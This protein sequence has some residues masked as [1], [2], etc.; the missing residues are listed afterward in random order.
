M[1]LL[2]FIQLSIFHVNVRPYNFRL[3]LNCFDTRTNKLNEYSQEGKGQ[4]KKSKKC[5]I[6]NSNFKFVDTQ[7]T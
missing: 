2:D 1:T 4:V 7:F 5:R 3:G 6:Y